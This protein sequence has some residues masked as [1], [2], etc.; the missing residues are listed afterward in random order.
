MCYVDKDIQMINM[1]LVSPNLINQVQVK[2]IF[3]KATINK[4]N[5][6]EP[7][8][9]HGIIHPKR[10][11]VRNNFYAYKGIMSLNLHVFIEIQKVI[12]LILDI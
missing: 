3:V 1:D 8:K 6:M 9:V 11:Y 2:Q 7:K 4:F 10:H 12:P 5:N